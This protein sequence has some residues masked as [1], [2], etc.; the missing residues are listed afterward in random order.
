M[1]GTT[2]SVITIINIILSAMAILISLLALGASAVFYLKSAKQL[3]I[4][5][6]IFGG[7]IEGTIKGQDIS[8]RRDNSG[9]LVG[10]SIVAR[11]EGLEAQVGLGESVIR[12][13]RKQAK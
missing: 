11:V 1:S 3:K 5:I 13:L 2:G 9:D 7:F 8:F 6:N 12:V 10:L 4:A